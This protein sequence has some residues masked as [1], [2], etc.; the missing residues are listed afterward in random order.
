MPGVSVRYDESGMDSE[1]LT[2]TQYRMPVAP[3]FPLLSSVSCPI[4]NASGIC[5]YYFISF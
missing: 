4:G 2:V 3:T 1:Q 5:F